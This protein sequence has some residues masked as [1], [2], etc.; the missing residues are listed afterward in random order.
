M[1]VC[2][3]SY[4]PWEDFLAQ[5][6]IAVLDDD[7]S[8]LY[9]SKKILSSY[10]YSVSTFSH[11]HDFILSCRNQKISSVY[12]LIIS[13]VKMPEKSGIEVLKSIKAQDPK[14]KVLLMTSY[15]GE[16]EALQALE[17]G[18]SDYIAKPFESPSLFNLAVHKS[19]N[20][21]LP[22]AKL[23][24]KSKKNEKKG[25]SEFFLD[26]ESL[27]PTLKIINK[28]APAQVSI[29]ISGETG[30][31]K[32]VLAQHI[33]E[34]SHVT[35]KFIALN[36][37]AIP[38]DL[39]ES[40][41][42]GHEKGAFTGADSKKIG[43]IELANKG[44]LFLDEIGD[45]SL[46]LQ[47]KLLR[48]LQERKIRRVGGADEITID[49]R[50]LSATHK[51]ISAMV[52]NDLFREDLLYRLNT[53]HLTLPPLRERQADLVPLTNF[54][55]KNICKKYE[56]GDVEVTKEVHRLIS[57]LKWSGNVRELQN[58]LERSLLLMDGVRLEEL[59]T[60]AS[61]D[62]KPKETLKVQEQ[63]FREKNDQPLSEDEL[64]LLFLKEELKEIENYI[65]Q[66][67]L[68]ANKYNKSKTAKS[69]GIGLRTLYR[70]I[71]ALKEEES[72]DDSNS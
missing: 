64:K 30:T 45:L 17:L 13:D 32:E 60:K 55:V 8:S 62:L 43:L 56:L 35:G 57:S 58:T 9:L 37:S 24:S 63:S 6:C 11:Y 54:L 19:I 65:I 41:L 66:K 67:R 59:K 44:T 40:E 25:N 49:T 4:Y 72:T 22:S 38:E 52:E 46:V 47:A 33:H 70:K 29:L 61:T 42:F 2:L 18:A 53:I 5:I 21:T 51:D 48:F 39:L 15:A 20:K 28:V 26:S 34:V 71:D 27:L 69:L 14:A 1:P 31:G 16:D 12:G 10:N 3:D 68:E 36:C 7:E 23:P 50:V